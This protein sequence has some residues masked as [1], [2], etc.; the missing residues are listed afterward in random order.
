M[1][2][3]GSTVRQVSPSPLASSV[4]SRLKFTS[5]TETAIRSVG[6][7]DA[8]RSNSTRVVC[9]PSPR[10]M[11]VT[12]ADHETSR[13]GSAWVADTWAP[14]MVSGPLPSS[15]TRTRR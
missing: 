7:P 15:R 12:A 5:S 14:V 4:T 1:P 3:P 6:M 9:W 11:S 8:L 2:A 13:L 10:L